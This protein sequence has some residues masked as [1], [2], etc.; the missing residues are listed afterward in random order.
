MRMLSLP[1][2]QH[3]PQTCSIFTNTQNSD[4][5]VSEPLGYILQSSIT[6]FRSI[7]LES[8]RGGGSD[9]KHWYFLSS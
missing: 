7:K 9:N 2:A 8:F 3:W 1:V 5:A 6:H 4:L